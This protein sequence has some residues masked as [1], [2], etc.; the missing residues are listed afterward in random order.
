MNAARGRVDSAAQTRSSGCWSLYVP[1]SASQYLTQFCG[2]YMSTCGIYT[3][4]TVRPP[5][6]SV[7]PRTPTV[8]SV[9][10]SRWTKPGLF[11]ELIGRRWL[12]PVTLRSSMPPPPSLSSSWI[13]L[14]QLLKHDSL[15][16]PCV[17][18][19]CNSCVSGPLSSP[20]RLRRSDQRLI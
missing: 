3:K 5:H 20:Y 6:G 19:P 1:V 8:P 4:R 9:F 18:I 17:N 10:A 7:T 15:L 14:Y 11:D 13:H 2:I 16:F 12:R